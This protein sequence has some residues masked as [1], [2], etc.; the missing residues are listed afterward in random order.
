V[1][2]PTSVCTPDS[3]PVSGRSQR[4]PPSSG[5]PPRLGRTS[6][7]SSTSLVRYR[8]SRHTV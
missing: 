7:K 3:R 8:R 1:T 4:T 6:E 2:G 5:G